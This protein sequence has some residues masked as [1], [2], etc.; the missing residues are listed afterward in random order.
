MLISL[1][2]ENIAVIKNINFEFSEGFMVLTGETGAGKSVVIDS[3]NLLLG[4]K[5]E[6]ELI[7]SGEQQA[8]VSGLFSDLSPRTVSGLNDLGITIP[9]DGEILLQRTITQDGKSKAMIN[10][11]SI[12]LSMLK[13]ITPL[14]VSVHGQTDTASLQD[15]KNHLEILDTYAGLGDLKSKYQE[16]YSI[17]ESIRKEIKEVSEKASESE[18]LKEILEYQ[19]KDIESANLKEDEEDILVEK[20]AKLK[21]SERITKNSEFVFKALKGSEKG[22]VSYLLDRSM[23]AL[24][25]I[26]EVVPAFS[27]YADRLRECLYQVDD[28]AEEVYAVIDDIDGDPSAA[29]NKIESRLD[30]ISKLERKYGSTIKDV[31]AF[32]QKSK[33]ELE[34]LTNSDAVI[35]SL[36]QKEKKAYQDALLLAKELHE[37]RCLAA[38]SLEDNVKDTLEFLDMPKVVF[39]VSLKELSKGEEKLLNRDGG[40]QIE[41]YISANRGAEAQPLAK[42]ASGGELSR[43]MLALKSVISDKDGI[44]T[45]IYDEIDTGVSGKTARKIGIK[46]LSL[47]KST[48]LFSVTHSAQI[49]SLADQHFLISKGDVNGETETGVTILDTEGRIKELS[50]ILGGINITSSQRAAAE[51]MLM[52]KSNYI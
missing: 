52:E 40:D 20:R 30:K 2:I 6:R 26:S 32:C 48:Q 46:M 50:R 44:P 9:D 47:S 21:N 25:Q 13:S 15:S 51:D 8:M 16:S 24:N 39:F 17:L 14:L 38:K 5:A 42:I 27:E 4:Q 1:H 35:K 18:R 34:T 23:T 12:S 49:A 41:F 3:I 29:L 31:L 19:I 33:A 36:V 22:S 28:I 45:V 43:I 37:K 7:R 10:G 11:R